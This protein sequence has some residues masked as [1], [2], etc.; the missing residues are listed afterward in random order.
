MFRRKDGVKLSGRACVRSATPVFVGIRAWYEPGVSA[1]AAAQR[2]FLPHPAGGR[3]PCG[4]S[5]PAVFF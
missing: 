4:N 1:R 3:Q 5:T 2:E